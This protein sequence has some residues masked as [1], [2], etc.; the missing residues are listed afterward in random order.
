[1]ILLVLQPFLDILS[2]VQ[3]GQSVSLAGYFRLAVTVLVPVYV[4]F[5]AKERKKFVISMAVIV[6]FCALHV[7]NG[8]R[9]GY[10]SLFNDVKYLMLTIFEN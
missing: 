4:L 7:L 2:Y 5:F 9:V 10:I 1:M 3:R 6:G 8:F